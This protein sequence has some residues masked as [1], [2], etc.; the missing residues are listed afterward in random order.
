MTPTLYLDQWE[1]A[2]SHKILRTETNQADII[3]IASKALSDMQA[4]LL[5][6]M[7]GVKSAAAANPNINHFVN[8]SQNGYA[9]EDLFRPNRQRVGLKRIPCGHYQQ[10]K[11]EVD[12]FTQGL[13]GAIDKQEQFINNV[14][15]GLSEAG[16]TF[17]DRAD[18][19]MSSAKIFSGIMCKD[20]NEIVNSKSY[21]AHRTSMKCMTD[22]TNKDV[23]TSGYKAVEHGP[24]IA[25]LKKSGV[26]FEIRPS[27]YT[28]WAPDW[29]Q[30]AITA[31]EK[32]PGGFAGLSLSDYLEKMKPE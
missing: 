21:N 17:V 29:V 24:H 12:K 30:E 9:I 8:L 6:N 10:N 25:A 11:I 20:C 28:I 14:T 32:E 7:Q 16:K 22:T 18:S 19:H 15:A 13:K 3:K 1:A 27:G 5:H 4:M 2:H 26:H 23:R 31:W